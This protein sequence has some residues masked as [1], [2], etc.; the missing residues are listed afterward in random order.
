MKQNDNSRPGADRNGKSW[1]KAESRV[2]LEHKEWSDAE[3]A[4]YIGRTIAAVRAQ[5]SK[6]GQGHKRAK[7]APK[8]LFNEFAWH[9]ADEINQITLEIE[10]TKI[11]VWSN[12]HVLGA[13]IWRAFQNKGLSTEDY[14]AWKIGVTAGAK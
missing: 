8:P 14:K 6:L 11:T 5:R 13:N 4:E 10:G 1:C 7:A 9:Q 3:I 12:T 2:I